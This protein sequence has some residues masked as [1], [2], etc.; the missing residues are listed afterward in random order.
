MRVPRDADGEHARNEPYGD[1]AIPTFK[2]NLNPVLE[3]RRI[4]EDERQRELAKLLRQRMILM[5]QLRQMQETIRNSKRDLAGSLTGT[6]DL[7]QVSNFARYSGQSTIRAQ[8]IVQRLAGLE[9]QITLGRERLLSASRDRKAL[10]L[11]HDKRHREWLEH[12][13]RLEAAEL[14]DLATQRHLRATVLENAA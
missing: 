9:Q 13:A 3:H 1:I 12:E 8:Q 10:E 2:F 5:D 4:I 6:V 11:L 14:D 7:A